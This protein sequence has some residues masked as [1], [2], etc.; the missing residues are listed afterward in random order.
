MRLGT[1]PAWWLCAHGVIVGKLQ[2][3]EAGLKV[4]DSPPSVRAINPA[5]QRLVAAASRLAAQLASDPRHAGDVIARPHPL[6]VAVRRGAFTALLT[7]ALVWDKARELLA[8][9]GDAAACSE[10]RLLIVGRPADP[11]LAHALNRGLCALLPEQPAPDELFV[12]LYN[13]FE[14]MEVQGAR[15]EPRQVAQPLPLRARRADRNRPRDH[16]RARDR[17]AARP[18]PGEEP[19]HHRR[20]RR[21]HLRGRGRRHRTSRRISCASSFARTT[22]VAFDSREFT[23]PISPRSMAGYVALEQE[24]A[25]HR[26]RLRHAARLARSASIARSTR[27]SATARRAC[28]ARRSSRARARSSASSSSSTRSATPSKSCS[29][30][31]TSSEQVIAVRRA[32]RGAAWHARRAGRHRA[33][34]RDPVRRDPAASSRASCAPASRRSSSATR[35]PAVTRGASPISRWASRARS[36]GRHRPV[37]RSALQR[38][39]LREIEYASLLHDFGK[40]GVREQVLVKAKKLYAHE[41]EAIRQRFDFVIRTIEADF[42]RA[43]SG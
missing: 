7:P 43:S 25:P 4:S 13:A 32:Q 38:E 6:L 39:D 18:H 12:A 31:K 28:S 30:P 41:L 42:W 29:C 34:E 1:G 17:Q 22:R 16:H 23:M 19:L 24:D 9:F 15:R 10:L 35:R 27:R 20:R 33:R 11:D 40:I 5:A 3:T 36:S 2:T 21:Q 8:P 37:P 26:R 14:L